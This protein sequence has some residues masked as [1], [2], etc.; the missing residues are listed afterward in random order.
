MLG[1]PMAAAMHMA[2]II[3]CTSICCLPGGRDAMLGTLDESGFE[4]ESMHPD[5]RATPTSVAAHSLY[6]QADPYSV[7]EPDGVLHLDNARYEAI[8]DRR[9][10]VGGAEWRPAAR[11]SVKIEGAER[12]GE[13]AVMLAGAADARFIANI[14][15]ILRSVEA[16]VRDILPAD[17][18][19]PYKLYFRRYGLDGVVEWP[20]PSP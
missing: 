1:Y 12:I 6:E 16:T 9:V 5:R 18:E 17:P 19:Q 15:D 2:K 20:S 3:E 8:D 7:S 4:L 14:D 13:R 11:P 10:R